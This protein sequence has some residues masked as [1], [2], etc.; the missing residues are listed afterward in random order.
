MDAGPVPQ[1]AP[2]RRA[3]PCLPARS[4]R[5][6]GQRP[7]FNADAARAAFLRRFRGLCFRCLSSKHRRVDCRDPIRCIECK[8][9]G[10]I[11]K[12]CPQIRRGRTGGPAPT[13]SRAPVRERLRFPTPPP[14]APAMDRCRHTDPSRR[15]RDGH[16]VVIE[17]PEMEHQMF[18][19]RRH[20]VLLISTAERHAAS[21]M[22]VGHAFD[23]ALRTPA[24]L[25]RVTSHD[26]EDFLV[27]F[28]LPAHRDNAV[29]LGS[30]NVDGIAFTIKPWHEDIHADHEDFLLHVRVVIEKM[31]MHL[32]SVD[33]AAEVLGNKCII[34]RLDSRTH[35]RGHTRTFACWVWA[36]DVAFIPTKHT[37][38]RAARGAGRVETMLGYSPPS[39]EVPPPPRVRRNVMLIHVDRVEDWTPLTPRS[40]HSGQSGIPS[41]GS[42]DDRPFPR[43][44]P[45]TWS[46]HIEDGQGQGRRQPPLIGPSGCGGLQLGPR[47]DHDD[48]SGPQGGR[49]SWKDTLLG[50]GREQPP[51]RSNCGAARQRSR[52]PTSRRHGKD[53]RHTGNSLRATPPLPLL[54]DQAKG[55]AN[56]RTATPIAAA[57]ASD[58]VADFFDSTDRAPVQPVQAD[59]SLLEI[60]QAIA[61]TLAAPL[62][63]APGNSTVACR[64]TPTVLSTEV[65]LAAV[66]QQVQQLQLP[67]NDGNDGQPSLFTNTPAPLVRQPPARR[68]SAPPRARAGPT[69]QSA[70]QAGNTSSVPVAQRASLLLVKKLGLLGPKEAMTAKAAEALIKRFDEPLTDDDISII[71]KLTRLDP[72]ALR[73][74]G[75]MAGPDAAAEAIV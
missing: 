55:A 42:D 53:T 58:P 31:P 24:H 74:A 71:A 27:H 13:A 32:W 35:E 9:P 39:R 29:R 47:R 15:P 20:A 75:G 44:Y 63:F 38:W 11:A 70:R 28:E 62:E 51:R 3:R 65:Q 60:D 2:R 12:D 7:S 40:S 67:G 59:C 6:R 50:R 36:Y 17:S 48:N 21:P 52:T 10:H 73:I 43:V 34:D 19:L 33:G 72:E 30:I 37:I 8:L 14:P 66:T 54:S 41:S 69:R 23:A 64:T 61:S 26:P 68:T 57:P 18:L 22:S 1:R 46:M 5:P 45:G 16:K 4:R 25:L 56:G 49:R